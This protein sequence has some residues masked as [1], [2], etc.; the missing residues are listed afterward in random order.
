MDKKN[1]VY[2]HN[3]ILLICKEQINPEVYR[4]MDRTGGKK[5]PRGVLGPERQMSIFLS[6]RNLSFGLCV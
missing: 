4:E 3:G 2:I 6:L 1:E 5:L